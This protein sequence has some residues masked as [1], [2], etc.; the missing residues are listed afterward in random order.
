MKLN[1]NFKYILEQY[2]IFNQEMVTK[3][4]FLITISINISII[5]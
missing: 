3:V 2:F 4:Y 5:S 1:T